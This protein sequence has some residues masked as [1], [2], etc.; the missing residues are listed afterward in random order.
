MRL[1]CQDLFNFVSSAARTGRPSPGPRCAKGGA[2]GS[3][4]SPSARN[5]ETDSVGPGSARAGGVFLRDV[6]LA[7][8]T[9]LGL[10]GPARWFGRCT[11]AEDLHQ[12]LRH[13]REQDLEVSILAGG[14][15]VVIAD[16]GIDGLVLEP[17]LRGLELRPLR[18]EP[19]QVELRAA[20]G[21]PWDEVVAFAV[22]KGLAGIECLSGI[23]GSTGAV[24][25][26]NVG[27]YGQDIASVLTRVQALDRESLEIVDL[28]P[29]ELAFSYRDS[30]LRRAPHRWIVLEVVLQLVTCPFGRAQYD[31]LRKALGSDTAPLAELRETVLRLRRSKSMVLDDTDENHRSVGSFWKN[32]IVSAKLA[33]SIAQRAVAAGLCARPE[34][35]PRFP[36]GL[37][38]LNQVKLPA[39]WLVERAGFARG[40]RRGRVGVSSRHTL[41]LVH[42]GA[43]TTA[44]LLE[45]ASEIHGRV[46]D[47]F[48]LMLE[49]EPV[50]LGFG[51]RPFGE[52]AD[53]EG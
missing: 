46:F 26:Q 37:A 1:V 19:G 39:A 2:K 36:A 7:A 25:V 53:A 43:G 22:A 47:C 8:R 18:H 17:A 24:P 5:P 13:A 48:G 51:S 16:A 31:E 6:A 29:T 41:A 3:G 28:T 23:P 20:A 52:P 34:E 21:E 40:F 15:N 33:E 10:G 14:S 35:L 42:H 27:A 49:P 12:A 4:V 32:P 11:S 38:A 50:F 30:A 9:T 45:L 44:E